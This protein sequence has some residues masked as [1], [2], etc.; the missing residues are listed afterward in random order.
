MKKKSNAN[1]F[2]KEFQINFDFISAKSN[3]IQNTLKNYFKYKKRTSKKVLQIQHPLKKV[4][5]LEKN[6]ILLM[7][8][9][10]I[11][12]HILMIPILFL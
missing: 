12:M 8:Y 11:Q 4:F 6:K 9:I 2:Q 10:S 1:Y 5:Q 3:L 7:K